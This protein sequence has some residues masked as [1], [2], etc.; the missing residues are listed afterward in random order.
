MIQTL[1]ISL[2]LIL[3]NILSLNPPSQA[4]AAAYEALSSGLLTIQENSLLASA[5]LPP[6]PKVVRTVKMMATAY[7]S[8]PEETDS[9]P[10]ITAA[11]TTVR[12]GIVANNLLPFGT[13]IR[14]P[15]VYGDKV[16]VVEDRMHRRK[17]DYHVDV[18]F[19][20]KREAK[21]FGAQV[22]SVEILES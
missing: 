12:D 1:F 5:S 15:E 6:E 22:L 4:D 2:G 16:F 11:G 14:L 18:W 13:K 9:T 3:T 20:T 8:T 10:F 19:P 17:G 7:S 21:I